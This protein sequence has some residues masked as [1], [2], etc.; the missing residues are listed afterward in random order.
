MATRVLQCIA[1]SRLPA[2]KTR[3]L[4]Q[5]FQ[6]VFKLIKKYNQL[7]HSRPNTPR[8]FS[9]LAPKRPQL[10]SSSLKIESPLTTNPVSQIPS[11]NPVLTRLQVRNHRRATYDPSHRVRKRRHGFLARLRSRTGRM[12]LARRR[13]KGRTKL[14]H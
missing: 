8:F 3:Q 2:S 12:I 4:G 13:A 1:R 6:Y 11:Q 7:N 9:L 10:L 14:S 5:S